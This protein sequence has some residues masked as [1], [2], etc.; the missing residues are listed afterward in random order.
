MGA[1][2]AGVGAAAGGG[3]G[4]GA[5][6]G[7]T[8]VKRAATTAPTGQQQAKKVAEMRKKLLSKKPGR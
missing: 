6:G 5:G 2:G 1:A 7:V 8:G 3:G 4:A